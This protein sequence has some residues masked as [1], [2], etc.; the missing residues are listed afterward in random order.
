MTTVENLTLHLPCGYI[1]FASNW[2]LKSLDFIN[3]YKNFDKI[4]LNLFVI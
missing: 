1:I 2:S 3:S 4:M